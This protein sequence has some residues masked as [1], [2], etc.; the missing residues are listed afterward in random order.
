LFSELRRRNVF[1]VGI[2]YVIVA[3][4]LLQVA[5]TLGPALRLPEWFQSGVVFVLILGFPLVLIFAWAFELTPEGLKR[6]R[7]VDRSQSITPQTG[8]KLNITIIALLVMAVVYLG[9]DKFVF[10]H[11][12]EEKTAKGEPSI[13][14]LPFANMSDDTSNEYFADGITEEL[15]NLLAKIPELQVTSRTSAFQF[16]GKEIDIPT[17]AKQLNVDHVLEGSVR[18][19]GLRVRITAQLIDANSDK[20]VWSE[21]YDRELDDIFAI[22]DEIAR[23]VVDVLHVTLLGETPTTSRTDADAYA[24]YLEG[25]HFMDLD[26]P[27]FWPQAQELFEQALEIDPDYAPAWFGKAQAIREMANWG[28]Y[29]LEEGTALARQW[30]NHALE[31]DPTLT[32]AIAMLAHLKLTY[33]WDWP[34]AEELVNR[35]LRA[36]PK[37]PAA[38]AE[39]ARL[40]QTLGRL[41][42]ARS[43]YDAALEADPLSNTRLR[44][45][46]IAAWW[47]Q[48]YARADALFRKIE[49]LY[50]EGAWPGDRVAVAIM[51]GRYDDAEML[52][53]AI[54]R[55][56]GLSANARE[57]IY[58]FVSAF[59]Y[60]FV[61]RREEAVAAMEWLIDARGPALSYQYAEMYA[62]QGDADKAFAWLDTGFEYHD[63]GMTY[64][65]VDPWLAPLHDDPRWRPLLAKMKLL[66]YWD[67]MPKRK[68][69]KPGTPAAPI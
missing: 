50:P 53:E 25:L 20:H 30:A 62:I 42:A 48:D 3:W 57:Y 28:D 39:A 5:D 14:V 68:D 63:G 24:L 12:H 59:A 1:R 49:T 69:L 18:K 66:E 26:G 36:G 52:T 13:A 2:A 45:A 11:E 4:L 8:Q 35:A 58:N 44:E 6:E 9:L 7:D 61:G 15:L 19:A 51:E 56:P 65:L 37:S 67:A 38:L 41:D 32:E 33:D 54:P 10:E 22:Q 40:N 16:K 21:T 64:L 27:E 47:Q 55:W 34:A 43:Y 31:L 29:N 46:G 60:P 23:K 17:V